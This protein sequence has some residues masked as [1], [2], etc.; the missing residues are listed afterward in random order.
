MKFIGGKASVIQGTLMRTMPN[1]AGPNAFKRRGETISRIVTSILYVC[2]IWSEA[3]SVG[4]IRRLL[5]SVYRLKEIRQIS[6]FR[7]VSDEGV[8]VLV[9][10]I[11]IDIL[12]DE[13]RRI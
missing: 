8:L 4:T 9:K 11:P 6:G 2:P 5:S 1:I 13:K 7:T 10:T 3:L 12:A